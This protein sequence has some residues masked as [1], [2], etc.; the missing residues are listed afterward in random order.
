MLPAMSTW[1]TILLVG[2]LTG[3]LGAWGWMV[4]R[5]DPTL[6]GSLGLLALT[7]LG[8][9]LAA[10]WHYRHRLQ[11]NVLTSAVA[12][13]ALVHTALAALVVAGER[14]GT[15]GVVP[16]L[17]SNGH[18]FLIGVLGLAGAAISWTRARG[19]TPLARRAPRDTTP[20]A[21]SPP[22]HIPGV[23]VDALR[24]AVA[25]DPVRAAELERLLAILDAD[26]LATAHDLAG[27]AARGLALAASADARE[28]GEDDALSQAASLLA[29]GAQKLPELAEL[30]VSDVLMAKVIADIRATHAQV[31]RRFVDHRH[32]WPIHPIDRA[33]ADAKCNERADAARAAGDLLAA[34]DDRLSEDLIAAEPAL[35]AF[36]SVT[37][38]Q[39]VEMAEADRYV[40]FEGNGRREALLRA[41][42]D[43]AIQVEVR[44]YRFDDAEHTRT[45]Q[46]RLE[47][48]RRWKGLTAG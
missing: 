25:L 38:F 24:D 13:G 37:G 29:W 31:E 41:F 15:L 19:R 17:A 6:R 28:A 2:V 42:P 26:D 40:T 9:T 32:L 12:L 35:E 16:A 5:A 46:R 44:C 27:R 20:P 8:G 3:S 23:D 47:R 48:V 30:D 36:R 45:I 10:L 4:A 14:L 1:R 39:V 18:H 34:H 43:R 11:A 22:R 7:M 33:T 21:A